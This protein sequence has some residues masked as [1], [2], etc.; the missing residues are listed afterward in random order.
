MS[1]IKLSKKFNIEDY[2][3]SNDNPVFIIAEAGVSHFGSIKK[4]YQLVDMAVDAN[5][6]S[7]KFQIFD[8]DEM[9]S[10]QDVEWK[11]RINVLSF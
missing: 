4:A 10:K 2:T 7:I 5:A 9:I 1:K 8:V 11:S 6:D 3:L